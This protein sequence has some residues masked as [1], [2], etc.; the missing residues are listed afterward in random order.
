PAPE[1]AHK[2]PGIK[3]YWGKEITINGVSI[4][5]DDYLRGQR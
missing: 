2:S 3:T 4:E 1:V 5:G